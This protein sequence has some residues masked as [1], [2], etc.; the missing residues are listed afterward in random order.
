MNIKLQ[1]RS[2]SL[3]SSLENYTKCRLVLALSSFE[4]RFHSITV[5]LSDING[6]RGGKDKRCQLQIVM[7]GAPNII[8]EETQENMYSAIS[9]AIAKATKNVKRQFERRTS[10]LMLSR[11]SIRHPLPE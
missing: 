7:D 4:E 6:P 11:Q 10:R 8:A 9:K 1:A 5:R 2:F 3:T